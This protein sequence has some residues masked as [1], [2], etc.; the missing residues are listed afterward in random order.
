MAQISNAQLQAIL[1]KAARHAAEANGDP[2]PT[3]IATAAPYAVSVPNGGL[4]VAN[5]DVLSALDIYV[6][7]T[8]ADAVLTG[9]VYKAVHRLNTNNP[10]LVVDYWREVLDGLDAYGILAGN[11]LQPT[12]RGG[13]DAMLRVINTPTLT[14]RASGTFNQYFGRLSPSNVFPTTPFV[15]GTIAVTG[16]AA[17]TL[18]LT[19]ASLNGLLDTTKYGPGQIAMLNSKGSANGSLDVITINVLKN[20]VPTQVVFTAG[21][22]TDKYLTA[23]TGDTTQTFTGLSGTGGAA[24]ATGCALV[25]IATGTNGD[26]FSIVI[27]PDRKINAA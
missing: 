6:L 21:A 24:G 25:S 11:T 10:Q 3:A 7:A 27:L 9:A 18:T 14:L 4:S 17:G 26:A 1:D 20:G 15:L 12:D 22:T 2:L 5:S 13:L 23:A 19:G 8:I 16:A